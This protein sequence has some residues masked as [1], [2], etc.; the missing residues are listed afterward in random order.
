[1]S[2]IYI[3]VGQLPLM[4]QL[5]TNTESALDNWQG[6]KLIKVQLKLS[7]NSMQKFRRTK[8][9]SKNTERMPRH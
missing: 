2:P 4:K 3:A 6:N 9:Y 7:V 5:S 1:M 8:H